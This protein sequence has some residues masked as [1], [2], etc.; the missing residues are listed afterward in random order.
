VESFDKENWHINVTQ[1]IKRKNRSVALQIHNLLV[2]VRYVKTVL[3]VH[4][5][6]A[7]KVA[8]FS[9]LSLVINCNMCVGWLIEN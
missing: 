8:A 1:F 3:F 5:I 9:T 7:M 6:G 2:V 4:G